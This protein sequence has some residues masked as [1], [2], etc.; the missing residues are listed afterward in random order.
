M[1]HEMY[2]YS[3][4]YSAPSTVYATTLVFVM[5]C[6]G[7]S[8]TAVYAA[9]HCNPAL[10]DGA[11]HSSSIQALTYMWRT[12]FYTLQANAAAEQRAAQQSSALARTLQNEVCIAIF[13]ISSSC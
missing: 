11:L 5:A 3:A 6:I 1:M 4:L 8:H 2:H 7:Y 9:P 13:K 12:G 10:V